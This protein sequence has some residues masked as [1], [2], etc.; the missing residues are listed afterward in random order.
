M[1]REWTQQSVSQI[2]VMAYLRLC[3][4][5]VILLM[6]VTAW[7]GMCLAVPGQL[8]VIKWF[9]ATLGIAFGAAS[10]AVVNHVLDRQIDAIIQ[11]IQ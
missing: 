10:G 11:R 1:L 4:C 2:P 6:L 9:L 3:K 5:R 8:N 7:V